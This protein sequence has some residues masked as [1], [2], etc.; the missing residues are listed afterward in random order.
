[1]NAPLI[2][3]LSVMV[4]F[5]ALGWRDGLV[6]RVLEIAGAMAAL[7]LTARFAG[8][9]QPWVSDRT[10]AGTAPALLITWV[11]LFILGLVLS[12]LL[13][14]LIAKLLHLT[15]LVWVDRLGGALLGLCFGT[16]VASALLVAASQ[17]RG[18]AVVQTDCDRSFAGRAIYYAAPN[19]YLQ[20]RKASGGRLEDAWAKFTT[21]AAE[22]AAAGKERAK[23][24]AVRH[25]GS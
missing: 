13:A 21:R 8:A 20:V 15:V 11:V 1:M 4:L 9:V 18:G 12:R 5:G 2:F 23:E 7:L 14:N 3:G 17:V 16:L 10:G 6:K 24:A 22:A 25:G 19:V